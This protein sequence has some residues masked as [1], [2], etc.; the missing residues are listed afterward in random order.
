M[1]FHLYLW[2]QWQTWVI[3]L[4]VVLL[5]FGATRLPAL[6]RSLGQSMRVFRSEL[7]NGELGAEIRRF[8]YEA[9]E[10][11][12][13]RQYRRYSVKEYFE[14]KGYSDRFL[15]QYLYPRIQGLFFYPPGGVSALPV[16]FVMNFYALQ[17]G[18]KQGS[19]PAAVRF[20]FKGGAGAWIAN[21]ARQI[22][23]RT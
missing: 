13:D 2:N 14:E 3:I 4:V 11:L 7:K 16:Q 21:L 12:R 20:N 5:L 23:A 18:Y 15:Q 6:A 10:V 8:Q 1:F 19:A 17:G 9:C 22:P